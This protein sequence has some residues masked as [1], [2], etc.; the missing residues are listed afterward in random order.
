MSVQGGG[1]SLSAVIR[2]I[3]SLLVLACLVFGAVGV[4]ADDSNMKMMPPI[5]APTA[6]L[7]DAR[8]QP[9]IP[10]PTLAKVIY[11]VVATKLGLPVR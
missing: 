6:P 1:L 3:A 7:S 9:P 5:P 4:F 11:L 2:R 8:M 10:A